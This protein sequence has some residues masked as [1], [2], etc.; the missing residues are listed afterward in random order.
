MKLEG[1]LLVRYVSVAATFSLSLSRHSPFTMDVGSKDEM[2]DIIAKDLLSIHN[3]RVE[4]SRRLADNLEEHLDYL[5]ALFAQFSQ[6]TSGPVAAKTPRFVRKRALHRIE[7]I[8]ENDVLRQRDISAESAQSVTEAE[9]EVNE[10][11]TVGRKSKRAASQRATDNIRKQ[12]NSPYSKLRRLANDET[13]GISE[14]KVSSQFSVMHYL[15]DENC[16]MLRL[17]RSSF[18]ESNG[19]VVYT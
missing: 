17:I 16:E 1:S 5:R 12:Q 2:R 15:C 14:K 4:M 18:G 7:T 11:S 13:D 19:I 8:P 3:R 9:K 10:V 6:P